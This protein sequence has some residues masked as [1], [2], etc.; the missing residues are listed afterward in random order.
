MD[1]IS[2]GNT[3]VRFW[4]RSGRVIDSSKRT[5]VVSSGGGENLSVSSVTKHDIWLQEEDGTEVSIQISG[6][7]IPIRVGQR[8]SVLAAAL[9][10]E[11]DGH[12]VALINHA[13]RKWERILSEEQ[14]RTLFRV[15]THWTVGWIVCAVSFLILGIGSTAPET[16]P[17]QKLAIA[18]PACGIAY[19]VYNLRRYLKSGERLYRCLGE[20]A[21][22]LSRE[23]Y[24]AT[25][26]GNANP[27][28]AGLASSDMMV[29][30]RKALFGGMLFAAPIAL[31]ATI[32]DVGNISDL[33]AG[34]FALPFAYFL[35]FFPLMWAV[36]SMLG[37]VRR[38]IL[39]NQSV[40]AETEE[41]AGGSGGRKGNSS[42]SAEQNWTWR[43][44]TIFL[45][46]GLLTVPIAAITVVGNPPRTAGE[47][48]EALIAVGIFT[49]AGGLLGLIVS[50]GIWTWRILRS[51]S[52]FE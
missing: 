46:V 20:V 36:L 52:D 44:V 6:Y 3:S 23:G 51:R 31:L 43:P 50:G 15:E 4:T 14:V 49:V 5:S 40:K 33:Q 29:L 48:Q 2:H 39:P 37:G 25:V 11:E 38:W 18:S 35:L 24:E 34:S 27:V 47:W 10:G 7:D 19:L 13:S 17:V 30:S 41:R 42:R 1:P 8:V 12:A 21:G 9:A 22:G 16:S 45:L 26:E 32:S 28:K